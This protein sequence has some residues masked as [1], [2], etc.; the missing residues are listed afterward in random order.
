MLIGYTVTLAGA[1]AFLIFGLIY[2]VEALYYT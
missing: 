1:A 2:L